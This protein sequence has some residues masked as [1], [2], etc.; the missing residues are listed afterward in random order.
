M[1]RVPWYPFVSDGVPREGGVLGLQKGP[2]CAADA[3]D[4]ECLLATSRAVRRT[5]DA[6]SYARQRPLKVLCSQYCAKSEGQARLR[7]PSRRTMPTVI[8]LAL[9]LIQTGSEPEPG[10]GY[11]HY[12]RFTKFD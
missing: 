4:Q 12:N 3:D 9:L 5:L 6:A 2:Y 1:S 8:M 10:A 11:A 7:E